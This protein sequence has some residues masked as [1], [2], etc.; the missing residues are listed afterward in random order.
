[1][2]Y[3]RL[4]AYNKILTMFTVVWS[5]SSYVGVHS[6]WLFVSN[7]KI[8]YYFC[9]YENQFSARVKMVFTLKIGMIGNWEIIIIYY[10]LYYEFKTN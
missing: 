1:M 9:I 4:I 8:I 2:Y 6:F 10:F 7:F 5:V 3:K